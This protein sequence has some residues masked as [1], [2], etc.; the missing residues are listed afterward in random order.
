MADERAGPSSVQ[1]VL[2]LLLSPIPGVTHLLFLGRAFIGTVLAV[3]FIAGVSLLVA[4]RL[5]WTGEEAWS[6]R[7]A[8]WIAIAVAVATSV[9]GALRWLVFVDHEARRRIR[10]ERFRRGLAHYVRGEAAQAAEAFRA[11]LRLDRSDA[12]A[13]F[14]LG[15]AL[16]R[17]GRLGRARRTLRRA[18]LWDPDRRWADEAGRALREIDSPEARAPARRRRRAPEPPRK[19]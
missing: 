14:H 2:G 7:L 10:E 5:V 6:L 8:G 17:Q 1:R 18:V 13:R 19:S 11:S 3:A 16:F 4:G 12:A 9:A 15:M